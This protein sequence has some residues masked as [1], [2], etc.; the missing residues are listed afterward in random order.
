MTVKDFAKQM[1]IQSAVASNLSLLKFPLAASLITHKPW[2]SKTSRLNH[3]DENS[4]DA[5]LVN[6]SSKS[7]KQP[8]KIW[9]Q[10]LYFLFLKLDKEKTEQVLSNDD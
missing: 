5:L 10:A 3:Q 7:V 8:A 6:S 1:E 9:E 2:T 4:G